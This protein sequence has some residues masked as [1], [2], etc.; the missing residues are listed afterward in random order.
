MNTQLQ[1]PASPRISPLQPDSRCHAEEPL[2]QR[3]MWATSLTK[4]EAETVL[5]WLEA[6]GHGHCQVSYVD[7]E[8]FAVTGA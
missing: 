8:G 7:G 6:Q 5:D 1:P 3:R 4:T 2:R